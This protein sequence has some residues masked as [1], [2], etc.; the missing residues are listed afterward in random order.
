MNSPLQIFWPLKR[1]T[2]RDWL[3]AVHLYIKIRLN[4]TFNQRLSENVFICWGK[5]HWFL[6]K[7]LNYIC[8]SQLAN[9]LYSEYW[10]SPS[11]R[12]T[13]ERR[14][15]HHQSPYHHHRQN[16]L[17][18]FSSSNNIKKNDHKVIYWYILHV[19]LVRLRCVQFILDTWWWDSRQIFVVST[20]S[21]RRNQCIP[22]NF[23]SR[24]DSG[25]ALQ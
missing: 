5:Q 10:R 6:D 2:R 4:L 8:C 13:V 21:Q 19:I 11:T 14:L 16:A 15:E 7:A 12:V 20:Q 23:E 9:Y 24:W 1:W 25:I 3:C 17:Y 22:K 18:N